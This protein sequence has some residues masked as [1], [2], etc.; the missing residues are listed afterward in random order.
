MKKNNYQTIIDFGSSELRLAV[1]NNKLSKLYFKSKFI[2]QKKNYEEYSKSINF[3]IRDAEEK[4][5][6]HLENI[7]VLYD[8]SEICTIDLSIKKKLDQ[9]TIFK[10]VCSSAI[11]EANQL[12]KDC[13]FDQKIIHLI[14]KKYIINNEEFLNIPNELPEDLNSVILEIKF[15]CLPYNQYKNI[16][17]IFKKNNIKIL[18]FFS[19]SL[20]KSFQYID[21]FKN[22]FVAFLDIGLDRTTIIFFVN[23]KLESFN[24]ISI[25][26]NH[27]SNDISQIM[28]LS[29]KESEE[30]KKTFNK[31]EIDF[32]YNSTDSKN[33]TNM[34]KKIIGKNIS[35]DLL[36]KVVLSRIEEI[37]ELSF[38]SINIS[39][40][41]D[42]QQNL[43]LVLIGKGSKIFN[44]NSFQIEDNYNFNE[45]NFYEEN[46]VEICR[47]GLIFEENFQNENL[48]N[49]KKNQKKLGFFHRFF[50]IFGNV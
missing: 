4:I 23:Q 19:S 49:L 46:D 22:K 20:V 26:G 29:L 37:I 28:K 17:E 40:N 9:K 27:I 15:I 12:V 35:I 2:S 16:F 3:L 21:L 31:S 24:S 39:N 14:I 11:L 5:S 50:N 42:K 6:S 41:I 33:D 45:I 10:D 36:K 38:K 18:N 1:F 48:Q 25:G 47:A 34:I 30:L 13:Y 8:T 44:K 7:T 43:N 32:S